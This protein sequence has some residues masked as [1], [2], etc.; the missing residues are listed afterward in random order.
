MTMKTLDRGG[1]YSV[2][3]NSMEEVQEFVD[4]GVLTPESTQLTAPALMIL[5]RN[6]V[7]LRSEL[8]SGNL[9]ANDSAMKL[10]SF[11]LISVGAK[12]GAL[13]CGRVLLEY[14]ADTE[15]RAIS[16]DGEM[17]QVGTALMIAIENRRED[18]AEMLLEHGASPQALDPAQNTPAHLATMGNC[19]RILEALARHGAACLSQPNIN[20]RTPLHLAVVKDRGDAL[21]WLVEHDVEINSN[22]DWGQTPLHVAV[23][24]GNKTGAH[25]LIEHGAQCSM[26]CQKCTMQK[27][28]VARAM[29]KSAAKQAVK[30]QEERRIASISEEDV[31]RAA[32][33]SAQLMAQE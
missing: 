1:M 20:G 13:E 23:L 18:Y 7:Q 24:E 5:S 30:A 27:K 29:K 28:L 9:N 12:E 32:E 33:L 14:G 31:H 8:E 3:V 16:P 15:A 10:K 26:R 21:R 6:A 11:P 4:E 22:D 19:T 25:L 17:E 2:T